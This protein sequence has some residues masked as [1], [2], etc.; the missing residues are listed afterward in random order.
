MNRTEYKAGW[1]RDDDAIAHV[2]RTG[3][4]LWQEGVRVPPDTCDVGVYVR[5]PLEQRSDRA[6][7]RRARGK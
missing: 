4:Q 7:V 5:A 1:M 2:K 6:R 3:A